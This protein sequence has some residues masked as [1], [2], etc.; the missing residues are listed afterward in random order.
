MKVMLISIYDECCLGLRRLSAVLKAGKHRSS[1]VL[2]SSFRDGV[3]KMPLHDVQYIYHDLP[4]IGEADMAALTDLARRLDPDLIGISVRFNTLQQ[5]RALTHA[6]RQVSRAPIIWGGNDPTANPDRAIEIAD[7]VC[8]G[9][10]DGALEDL[11]ARLSAGQDYTDIPNLWVRR[12]GRPGEPDAISRNHVRPLAPDLDALP[13]PDFAY[14]TQYYVSD[15]RARCNYMSPISDL[16]YAFPLM[17]TSD[18]PHN[19]SYCCS[20][21]HHELYGNRGRVRLRSVDNCLKEL[22]H[23]LR[24][25]PEMRYVVIWDDVFGVKREWLREFAEAYPARIGRPFSCYTHPNQVDEE[26]VG[27]LKQAGAVSVAMGIQ[28]GSRRIRE[29]I[30]HRRTPPEKILRATQ[31]LNNAG[32]PVAIDLIGNVPGETEADYREA[33]ELLL[34]LPGKFVLRGIASLAIFRNYPIA[35]ILEERGALPP[36]LDGFNHTYAPIT[37]EYIFWRSIL[38]LC[39][40]P[41]MD[42]PTLRTLAEDPYLRQHPEVIQK[43]TDALLSAVYLPQ[44][45]VDYPTALNQAQS[46]LATL[47]GSRAIRAVLALKRWLRR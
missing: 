45:A 8:I 13:W 38:L 4:P 41:G 17:A 21:L 2:V 32:L 47:K 31:L 39:G 43:L 22:K 40:Q 30:F 33:F 3:L 26:Y 27:L 9:E 25:H 5:A 42:A 12:R 6:L 19:C 36:W 34:S 46:E 35:R 15:G 7:I 1:L 28:S 20:S 11:M 10:G 23:Q 16:N 24:R 18:C 37:P 29:E 44:H 14:Q